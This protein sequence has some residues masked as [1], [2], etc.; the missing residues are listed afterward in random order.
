MFLLIKISFFDFLIVQWEEVMERSIKFLVFHFFEIDCQPMQM[1]DSV[2]KSNDIRRKV[3]QLN[4]YN[5]FLGNYG[6]NT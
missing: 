3:G 5:G 6:A 2:L 4:Q 1:I